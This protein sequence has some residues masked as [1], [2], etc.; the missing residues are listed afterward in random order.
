MWL[1]L[2]WAAA[3]QA[4]DFVTV[5]EDETMMTIVGKIETDVKI[6][7][8]KTIT[9]KGASYKVKCT[10]NGEAWVLTEYTGSDS[11]AGGLETINGDNDESCKTRKP[12]TEGASYCYKVACSSATALRASAAAAVAWAAL[13]I[14]IT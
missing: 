5:Y 7:E 6:D 8:C 12:F 14:L 3:A 13:I 2:L 1:L 11:C 10:G 9:G 4:A